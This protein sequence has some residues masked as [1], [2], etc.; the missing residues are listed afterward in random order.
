MG[1]VENVSPGE[2]VKPHVAFSSCIIF[3]NWSKDYGNG[4]QKK[5]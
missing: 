5:A 2:Y 1:G 4:D 3:C